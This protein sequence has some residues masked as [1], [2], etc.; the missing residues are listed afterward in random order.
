MPSAKTGKLTIQLCCAAP[1]CLAQSNF[2][3]GSCQ[4][5]TTA[6]STDSNKFQCGEQ[7][8]VVACSA[9]TFCRPSHSNTFKDVVRGQTTRGLSL[10]CPATTRRAV[11]CPSPPLEFSAATNCVSCIV[12]M[13]QTTFSHS[14]SAIVQCAISSTAFGRA[15]WQVRSD[16]H[17]AFLLVLDIIDW[18]VVVEFHKPRMSQRSCHDCCGPQLFA[19]VGCTVPSDVILSTLVHTM[20]NLDVCQLWCTGR[21]EET[22]THVQVGL[23]R[24]RWEDAR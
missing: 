8:N 10:A 20:V 13:F 24:R 18:S 1:M 23:G 22:A 19:S 21:H 14:S 11:A 6:S 16:M 7:Q 3:I 12:N 5:N 2:Q 4:L 9:A 15:T 17:I